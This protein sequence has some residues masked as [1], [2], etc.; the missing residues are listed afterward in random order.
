MDNI[1][2]GNVKVY[3]LKMEVRR[4]LT[5]LKGYRAMLG[6]LPNTSRVSRQIADGDSFLAML[7]ESPYSNCKT[8]DE[9]KQRISRKRNKLKEE[10]KALDPTAEGH[11]ISMF[12]VLGE[13]SETERVK[14]DKAITELKEEI[15]WLH[16]CLGICK[17]R[18]YFD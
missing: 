8:V 15:H 16:K 17:N 12:E 6:G 11:Q 5:S 14:R 7:N 13:I 4:S 3:C 2:D 1:R 10:L 18:N 9:L